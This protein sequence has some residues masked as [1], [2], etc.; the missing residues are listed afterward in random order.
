MERA[1]STGTIKNPLCGRKLTGTFAAEM[2]SAVVLLVKDQ[3]DPLI[4]MGKSC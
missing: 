3:H 1:Y 4:G 2:D